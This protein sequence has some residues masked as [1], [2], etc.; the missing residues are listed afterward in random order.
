[1]V[2]SHYLQ[3][4]SVGLVEFERRDPIVRRHFSILDG[5]IKA[6]D[7]RSLANSIACELGSI[8]SVR[9]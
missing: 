5:I 8:L 9:K 1:M 7:D 3:G 6:R 2:Y 4:K